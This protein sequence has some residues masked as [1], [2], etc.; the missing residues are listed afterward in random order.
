MPV[1][2]VVY[3]ADDKVVEA[4]SLDDLRRRPW[5]GEDLR[6]LRLET[7][8]EMGVEE[9]RKLLGWTCEADQLRA[10]A[11]DAHDLA[12]LQLSFL[13]LTEKQIK[14]ALGG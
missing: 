9:A 10:E 11:T 6:G 5:Q 4:R 14:G 2:Q 13:G 3:D 1:Y 7:G 8:V 12:A